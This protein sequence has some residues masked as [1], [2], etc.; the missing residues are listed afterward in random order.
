MVCNKHTIRLLLLSVVIV[1]MPTSTLWDPIQAIMQIIKWRAMNYLSKVCHFCFPDFGTFPAEYFLRL[2]VCQKGY[3][4]VY[5]T[6]EKAFVAIC[7][8]SNHNL[9]GLIAGLTLVTQVGLPPQQRY[10]FRI[11]GIARHVGKTP[12]R[13]HL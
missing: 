2:L 4:Y 8:R 12:K 11:V 9:I 6:N 7:L 13:T 10:P 5:E 3:I 1:V